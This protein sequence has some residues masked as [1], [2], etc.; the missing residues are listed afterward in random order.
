MP[1][2][3][4]GLYSFLSE[5]FVVCPM[6]S[7]FTAPGFIVVTAILSE[8]SIL[9]DSLIASTKCFVAQYTPLF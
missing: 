8:N 5:S 2:S 4:L 3:N 6:N 7:V 1:E 9:N